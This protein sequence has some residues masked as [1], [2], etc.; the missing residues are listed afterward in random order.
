MPT[1]NHADNLTD[2]ARAELAVIGETLRESRAQKGLSVHEL[3]KLS[4]VSA[5][6]ISQIERGMANPSINNI[7]K[8]ASALELRLGVFFEQ[9]AETRNQGV[10]RKAERRKINVPDP[11]FVYE[12]LSPDLNHQLEFVWIESAPG[13]STEESPFSHEGEECH[14]LLQGTLEIHIGDECLVL[15][16]GDSHVLYDCRIPHW[17]RNPGP[18]RVLAI[19]AITPPTF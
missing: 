6:T 13:S 3:A 1:T 2:E 11:D 19:S 15:H 18:E 9:R 10:V 14:L 8:L 17:Y 7:S 5:G 16:A 12:L 4:G